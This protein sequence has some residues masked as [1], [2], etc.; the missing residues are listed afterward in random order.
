[1][2][3]Q[4]ACRAEAAVHIPAGG[5]QTVRLAIRP[6]QPGV[7]TGMVSLTDG[8]KP[9]NSQRLGFVFR[10]E[11]I[12]P[13]PVPADFDEFWD[14]TLAELEQTPLDLTM[15]ERK[16]LETALGRVYK[17]QYR[18]WGGRWAW[19][20]LNVPKAEGK[21]AGKLWLPPNTV[22]QPPPP[23]PADGE[24]RMMVAIHGGDLADWPAKPDFDYHTAG[25]TSRET[26]MLRYS[27]CCLV[28]CYDIM[29]RFE[30]CNGEV[31]LWGSSQGGGLAVILAG[32]RPAKSALGIVVGCFRM[33][34]AVRGYTQIWPQ[35]P[36]GED[37][38]KIAQIEL[39]F[40]AASF[41]HRVHTPLKL[42]FG[43]FDWTGP[44]E[45]IFTG[46][47][48]LPKDTPCELRVDPTG[49]AY[50]DGLWGVFGRG[51]GWWII[52]R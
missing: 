6:P 11:G 52:G 39:Y 45:G 7:Y 4:P 51:R 20:W 33:D 27:Y 23:Q 40:D 10:P 35:C 22:Y 3:K 44:A 42:A 41:A 12:A 15:T 1:M 21:T 17:V 2:W 32:L 34:W 18:S 29:S 8:Q 25:M 19:A 47:N 24:L 38:E 9:L 5:E 30:K 48:T 37:P 13:V 16:D 31:N 26:Y 14:K 50:G 46:L 28:R 36:P 49:G 43:L